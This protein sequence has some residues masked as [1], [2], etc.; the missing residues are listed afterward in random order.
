MKEKELRLALVLFGGVSLAVYQHGINR[1]L[2]NL[3]RASRAYHR[4]EGPAAKQAPGHAYPAGAGADAWTAEVYFDLLKRLGRTVD[5]RVLVDVISG[6]SAGAINGIALA[7]A[8]AHDLSLAPVT[9]LW[10]ERADMQRLIAPEARAGRWDKWYF[11]PLLRPL[12]AWARR[13]GMLEAQP[14]PETLERA[15]AFVRSRWFS[16]PLDGAL[17][18]AELLDG[19]LAMETGSVAAGSLL[20]SGTCLS[21]AVTVT[22][23]RGIERALFTHDPPLLR[24]REHRHLL[25]FACEHRR[26]GELDSDFGLDNAPSLAF[27][28]RAS[29]C[30]SMK[31]RRRSTSRKARWT[32][33]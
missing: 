15:L 28:A 3:A 2:L 4:V 23:F 25:R 8:L 10:L 27:A 26:T 32:R 9:R 13:E 7:R 22:D 30:G 24:E 33:M 20:P 16:P 19:L 14:D 29:A 6:A 11:R 17:L 1:E 31:I 18:S 12:L 5:L 21:L